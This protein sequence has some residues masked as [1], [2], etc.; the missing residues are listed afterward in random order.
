MPFNISKAAKLG[1]VTSRGRKSGRST[2]AGKLEV[3]SGRKQRVTMRTNQ[4]LC[5][6][7]RN[8]NGKYN[9]RVRAQFGSGPQAWV[10][11]VYFLA[12]SFS[13]GMKKLE[14]SLQL[15]QKSEEKLRFWAVERT[16]DPNLAGDLLQDF[17]LR[18]DRRRDFPRRTGAIAVTRERPVPAA[19]LAPLRRVLA[20]AV[21]QERVPLAAGD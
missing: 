7:E 12:S 3:I 10:L 6:M 9:V 21:A 4:Y 11:P 17:G 19:M 16:D 2:P 13:A 8:Q 1:V 18:L 15:L 20:D 5:T 14:E